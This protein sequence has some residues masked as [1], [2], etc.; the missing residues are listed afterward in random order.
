[1]RMKEDNDIS[2][3]SYFSIHL[4]WSRHRDRRA[5]TNVYT[6]KVRQIGA[7]FPHLP[8][9][10]ILNKSPNARVHL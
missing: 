5:N 9:E 1:M 6:G 4:P 3:K 2:G 7:S 8:S 10:L